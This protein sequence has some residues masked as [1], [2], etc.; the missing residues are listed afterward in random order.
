MWL[1]LA[2]AAL[3]FALL[4]GAVPWVN[5]TEPYVLGLPFFLFWL[6]LSIVLTSVCMAVVYRLDPVNGPGQAG[7]EEE[8]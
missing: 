2:L 1:R 3:P 6:S 5:R 4:L 7:S 8:G